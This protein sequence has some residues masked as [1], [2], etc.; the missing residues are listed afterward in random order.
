MLTVVFNSYSQNLNTT[1]HGVIINGVK[2]AT[3]NVDK[4]GSFADKPEDVGSFYQ[5]NTKTAWA[6]TGDI[7]DWERKPCSTQKIW[8]EANDPSPK[9]WRVPTYAEVKKLLNT[10]KVSNEW[11]TE[12][13]VNGIKFTDKATGNTLFLPAAGFRDC[14]GKLKPYTFVTITYET[15][16]GH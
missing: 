13:G 11:T 12:N 15:L 7:T 2:W 16:F 5:W 4:P 9:G 6:A 8:E 3:R 1:D 10:K 14:G